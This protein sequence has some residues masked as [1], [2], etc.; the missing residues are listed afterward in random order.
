M[1]WSVASRS[2]WAVPCSALVTSTVRGSTL[3]DGIPASSRAADTMGLLPSSPNETMV[4]R[5]RGETSSTTARACTMASS[6][7]KC[8]SVRAS[9]AAFFSGS[10]TRAAMSSWRFRSA[11]TDSCAASPSPLSTFAA[12]S[13]SPSVTP[14]RAE[15]TTTRGRFSPP[16]MLTTRRTASASRTDVPPN[17]ITT[18]AASSLPQYTKP[19]GGCWP[20]RRVVVAVAPWLR[21]S[22]A[23]DPTADEAHMLSLRPLSVG[24]VVG[25]LS[26]FG[27]EY[28]GR[29]S[30]ASTRPGLGCGPPSGAP[31]PVAAGSTRLP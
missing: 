12:M 23:R 6:S 30:L 8:A 5:E 4:S 22:G 11:R 9:S 20:R 13:S 2:G 27:S 26:H 10:R 16:T 28:R 21:P 31:L 1:R 25:N 17:F 14:E 24:G 15:T 19:A 3:R 7:S 29:C 18:I